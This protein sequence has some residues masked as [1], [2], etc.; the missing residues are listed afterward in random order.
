M[1]AGALASYPV[2]HSH[3]KHIEIDI[4]FIRDKVLNR[5][6]EVCYVPTIGQIAD[7]LTKPL[8]QQRFSFLKSKSGIIDLP[9]NLR[10]M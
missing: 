10:G 8:S 9:S 5:T 1:G 7:C 3:T 4:H 2:F 6:L